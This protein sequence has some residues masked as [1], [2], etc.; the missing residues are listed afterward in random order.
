MARLT[1]DEIRRALESL[2]GWERQGDEIARTVRFPEFM[3]GIHFIGRVAEMAEAADHHPD[4]DIRYRN[5][6]FAL[7]T[8][9]QGGLTEKD[10]QLASEIN[11]AL[12]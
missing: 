4:I 12:G 3:D 9:D 11:Q 6:R 10:V 5:V 7:T 1:D 2:S 8:H